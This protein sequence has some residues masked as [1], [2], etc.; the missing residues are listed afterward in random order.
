MIHLMIKSKPQS[1]K[2]PDV[3]STL[4]CRKVQ[5]YLPFLFTKMLITIIELS[6]LKNNQNSFGLNVGNALN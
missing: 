2:P 4:M 6:E 3:L 1:F 5:L